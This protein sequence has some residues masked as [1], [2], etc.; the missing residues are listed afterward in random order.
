MA[1][2]LALAPHDR[3]SA[4][5]LHGRRSRRPHRLDDRRPRSG[6]HRRPA[7]RAAAGAAGRGRRETHPRIID[8]ADRA[9]VD[10]ERARHRR[11]AAAEASSVAIMRAL[12][13]EYDLGARASQIRDDLLAL[14][15]HATPADM[16][17]MQL[18][19]RA[20]FLT[21]WQRPARWRC[22]TTQALARP[23]A[24]RRSSRAA[25]RELERR[26]RASIRSATA[27]CAPSTIAGPSRRSWDMRAA[28]AR[29][30][31]RARTSAARAVRR[32]RCGSWS[33]R[34]PCTCS[35]ATYPSWRRL[36][37]RAGRCDDQR[38]ATRAA[39]ELAQLHLG[40]PQPGAASAIPCR[41]RFPS[42]ARLAR[43][44][45]P[46]A[47]RRSR[48]AARTGRRLRRVGAVRRLPGPRSQGYL[49]IARRA[50][51][52]IPLSPYYRAGFTDWA[53]GEAAA[54]AARRGAHAHTDAALARWHP[55]RR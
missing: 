22:S 10:G 16:L 14:S 6:G 48:H 7:E 4:P 8:P 49:Q 21:R 31:P 23:P 44:A 1:Q 26:A 50:R 51:A 12:G 41:A 25:D 38:P 55:R 19:D 39:R 32:R 52:A 9:A 53:R 28:R 45:D 13:A 35:A 2:A 11:P 36:P 29:Q 54:V 30:S 46:A 40:R 20:V 34:S 47:A 3:H 17:R 33:P 18:D 43:H 37:A 42:L 24:A 5:E 27:W 15:G